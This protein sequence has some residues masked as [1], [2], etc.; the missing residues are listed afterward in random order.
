MVKWNPMKKCYSS[1]RQHIT[2]ATVCMCVLCMAAR[3]EYRLTWR[4]SYIVHVSMIRSLLVMH[5]MLDYR[6]YVDFTILL[7]KMPGE[8]VA[9]SCVISHF[10]P[11]SVELAH[12]DVNGI[13]FFEAKVGGAFFEIYIRGH[14]RGH[15][16]PGMDCWAFQS[17]QLWAKS[18]TSSSLELAYFRLHRNEQ[19]V[20]IWESNEK[21]RMNM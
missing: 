20:H 1:A 7:T 18:I 2:N 19:V 21:L 17:A 9:H 10:T 8:N 3:Q 11:K 14:V 4:M 12:F 16:L 13:E 15:W 5:F 6:I